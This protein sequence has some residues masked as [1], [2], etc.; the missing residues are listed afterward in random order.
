MRL[1]LNGKERDVEGVSTV[2]ELIATLAI[3]RMIVVELNGAILRREDYPT[4]ALS[5]G[6]ALEIVHMVGGG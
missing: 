3:H 5:D 6:D 2:E 4:T 1:K